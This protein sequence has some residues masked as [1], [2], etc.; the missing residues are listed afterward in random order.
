MKQILVLTDDVWHPSEVIERGIASFPENGYAFSFVKTAKD[1]LT[2]AYLEPFAAIMI[3]KSNNVNAAN[4]EPWFE[5]TVSEVTPK[6]LSAYV[7]NG[8]G[9]LFV[10]SGTA[11][12]ER[13]VKKGELFERPNRQYMELMGCEMNGHPLRCPVHFHVTDGTHPIMEGVRD[14]TERDEHYQISLLRDD[15]TILMES[16]SEPG[17]RMPA[18]Y[19]RQQG[20]GKIAVFTPGHT[21]A[22]WMNPSFQRMIINALDWCVG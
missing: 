9:L 15:V 8:G 7:E 6:E 20:K 2:P 14:F 5:D 13:F 21:L 3:C 11:Y 17:E 1:I 16:D 10:H 4:P 22:V 12:N 19:V 18:A